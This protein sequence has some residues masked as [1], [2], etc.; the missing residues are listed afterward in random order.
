MVVLGWFRRW[1]M[2]YGGDGV[3][4][5]SSRGGDGDMQRY[6]ACDDEVEVMM[7]RRLEMFGVATAYLP[8]KIFRWSEKSWGRRKIMREVRREC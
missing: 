2:A 1:L 3:G 7:G 6:V 5:G 4:Y 8:E